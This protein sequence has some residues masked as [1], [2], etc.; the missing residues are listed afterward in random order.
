MS[1]P[2]DGKGPLRSFGFS[3]VPSGSRIDSA[4][5]HIKELDFKQAKERFL[6]CFYRKQEKVVNFSGK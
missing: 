5:N 6:K 2:P 1:R 4:Q 3:R